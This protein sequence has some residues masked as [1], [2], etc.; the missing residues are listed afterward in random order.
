MSTPAS[1]MTSNIRKKGERASDTK[2]SH[3]LGPRDNRLNT[4]RCRY[5]YTTSPMPV[6]RLRAYATCLVCAVARR[7]GGAF[8]VD[9]G[10]AFILDHLYT[11]IGQAKVSDDA[12]IGNTTFT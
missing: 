10:K 4:A 3:E 5:R 2:A 6:I 12:G 8:D 1:K 11:T 7:T 9:I